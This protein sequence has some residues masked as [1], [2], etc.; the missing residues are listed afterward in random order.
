MRSLKF[1]KM[2]NANASEVWQSSEYK[3]A[4]QQNAVLLLSSMRDSLLGDPY[5]G[6]TLKKYLFDQNN[7]VL[8]DIIIDIIYSQLVT[9]LPQIKI[10]RRDIQIIQEALKGKLICSFTG[11]S[12]I[13]FTVNTYSLN[14]LATADI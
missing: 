1:P 8:K 14:L 2:F 12:Q 13:D 3:E 4:T 11:V 9:F 7:Y 5:F 6:N 10:E